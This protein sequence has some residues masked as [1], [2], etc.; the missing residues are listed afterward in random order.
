MSKLPK[1]KP[2]YE[3]H[4]IKFQRPLHVSGGLQGLVLMYNED[5]SFNT[6]IP[7]TDDLKAMFGED[8]KMFYLCDLPMKTTGPIKMHREVEDPG[9]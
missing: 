3:R 4:I 2:G 6:M 8:E 1:I 9:W 5:R 7:Y